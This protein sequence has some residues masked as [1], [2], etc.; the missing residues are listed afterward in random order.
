MAFKK[1]QMYWKM[2]WALIDSYDKNVWQMDAKRRIKR[3][4]DISY[5]Y[6]C[7]ASGTAE[8]VISINRMVYSR[9]K[10]KH[11]GNIL[12]KHCFQKSSDKIIR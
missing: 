12:S 9:G 2:C 4:T 11:W 3:I 5:M 7:A 10:G 8:F 1:P 6:D